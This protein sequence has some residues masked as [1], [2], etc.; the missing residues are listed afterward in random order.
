MSYITLGDRAIGTIQADLG[1]QDRLDELTDRLAGTQFYTETTNTI[2]YMCIDG[3]PGGVI[4][5]NAA[6]GTESLFVADD[7][8]TQPIGQGLKTVEGYAAL[9]TYLQEMELPIGGHTDEHEHDH[10]SGC[11]GNDKLPLIYDF[12]VT[13]GSYLHEFTQKI[14][15]SINDE[16]HTIITGNAAVR[17]QFS[18]GDELLDVLRENAGT[19]VTLRGEHKEVVTVIN[20]KSGTTLDREKVA[21]EFGPDYQVFNIDAWSFVEAGRRIAASEDDIP[22]KVAAMIYYNLATVFVL[23]GPA[24]RVIVRE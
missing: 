15:F 19:I 23:C 8:T 17:Q 24:M 5:P 21:A 12:I 9:L 2:P 3:R 11:G 22:Q 14:G 16:T 18:G 4:A 1:Q 7:L 6:G 13:H 20:K 10:S